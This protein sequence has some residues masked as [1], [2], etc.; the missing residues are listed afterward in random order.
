MVVPLS[1]S[2]GG[3]TLSKTIYPNGW[4]VL[5]KIS[6]DP[7]G[8]A[9]S[10]LDEQIWIQGPHGASIEKSTKVAHDVAQPD[11]NTSWCLIP[12]ILPAELLVQLEPLVPPR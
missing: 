6:K 9:I 12:W 4:I 10:F 11:P 3:T 5:Y 7:T 1:V 8:K 2:I